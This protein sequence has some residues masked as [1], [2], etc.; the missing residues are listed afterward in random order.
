MANKFNP[1]EVS[2][3]KQWFNSKAQ[4][5]AVYKYRKE[6][7]KNYSIDGVYKGVKGSRH[8]GQYYVGSY[9]M[10]LNIY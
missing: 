9:L 5:V 6:I 10:F 8:A 2:P 7:L 3:R 4:A 1:A